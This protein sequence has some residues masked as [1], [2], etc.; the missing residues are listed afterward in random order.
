MFINKPLWQW[1]DWCICPD[2]WIYGNMP[3]KSHLE[4]PQQIVASFPW[5]H[6]HWILTWMHPY[7]LEVLPKHW[8][9]CNKIQFKITSCLSLHTVVEEGKSFLP[10]NENLLCFKS[11]SS[12]TMFLSLPTWNRSCL[13]AEPL[14]TSYSLHLVNCWLNSVLW[15][16][17]QIP[18]HV[19]TENMY[20]LDFL[21]KGINRKYN[22]VQGISYS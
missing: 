18:K 4:T 22:M 17:T 13:G 15:K 21:M 19:N 8:A 11:Y 1:S 7:V 14:L 12:L 6:F 9:T 2:S 20:L 5:Q 3:Y 16:P 10:L